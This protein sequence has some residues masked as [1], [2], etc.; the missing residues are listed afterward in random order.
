MMRAVDPAEMVETPPGE[1]MTS[2]A[3]SL[4]LTAMGLDAPTREMMVRD[5][6][7]GATLGDIART[8]TQRGG[9]AYDEVLED[10]SGR[11][12]VWRRWHGDRMTKAQD[13]KP[14]TPPV[15]S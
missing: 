14:G 6:R 1:Y 3:F 11:C 12:G 8:A 15:L 10:L 9:H 13:R 7:N 2:K 5:M 4:V